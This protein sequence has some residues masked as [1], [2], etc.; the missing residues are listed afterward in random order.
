MKKTF[1]VFAFLS[2][3]GSILIAQSVPP[4]FAFDENPGSF[5]M[6][7]CSDGNNFYSANGGVPEKGKITSFNVDGTLIS[8]YSLPLDMRSIMYDKKT[9]KIYVA[10]VDKKIIRIIDLKAGTYEV[11]YS[12]LYE[13]PQ[14][15]VTLGPKGKLL[16]AFDNG[17]LSIY[18][19]KKGTVV[20]IL[21]GLKC[22]D[23]NRKGAASVAVDAKYIYTWDSASKTVFAYDKSGRFIES[24]KLRDGDF[25]YSLSYAMGM[26]FVSSS[27][28]GKTGHWYG[29]KLLEQ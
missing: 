12:D 28:Q 17:T 5:S 3:I 10:T 7:L 19:F 18:N 14:S 24:F 9:K 11:V 20:Q 4:V 26:I 25:G 15:S 2:Y 21:S 23:G 1:L 27:Q 29:Y 8:S 22:G 16:Y 13:N 6:H